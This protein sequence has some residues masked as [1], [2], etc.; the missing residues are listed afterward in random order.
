M[1]LSCS[2]D[3]LQLLQNMWQAEGN[4]TK[5]FQYYV[6]IFMVNKDYFKKYLV[7]FLELL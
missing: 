5:K 2:P 3:K 7:T 1:E 4:Q 6:F